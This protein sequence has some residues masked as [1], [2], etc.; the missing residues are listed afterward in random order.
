MAY[1]E[2][3]GGVSLRVASLGSGGARGLGVPLRPWLA[4]LPYT[5][6]PRKIHCG[7][8]FGWSL[9]RGTFAAP[10]ALPALPPS[11]YTAGISRVV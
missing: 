1:G 11:A 3:I 8:P 5:D 4:R 9:R 2:S 7:T 10:A 6:D